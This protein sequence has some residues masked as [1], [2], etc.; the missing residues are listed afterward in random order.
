LSRSSA[1]RPWKSPF[2]KSTDQPS[3][4]SKGR[5]GGVVL[6]PADDEAALDPEEVERD[7]P[8]H[9]HPLRLGVLDERVPELERALA[10]TQSS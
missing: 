3:P 6:D 2:P 9:L 4:H 10:S 5:D 7:H 1:S 8:D